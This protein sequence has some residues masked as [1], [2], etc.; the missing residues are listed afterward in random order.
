MH[1]ENNLKVSSA[2]SIAKTENDEP[3]ASASWLAEF[4]AAKG[5]NRE[6]V[7]TFS[8]GKATLRFN[9]N[10][11]T[12]HPCSGDRAWCADFVDADQSTIQLLLEQILKMRPF[13]S[14]AELADEKAEKKRVD[15]ALMGIANTVREGPDTGSGI[16]L[17]RFLWSLYNGHHLVNLWRMTCVLDATRSAWVSEVFVSAL[18]GTL[19][20]DD[21]KKT[22]V[23]AGEMERWDQVQPS[24]SHLDALREAERAIESVLRT[25]PP[26]H[27]HKELKHAQDA[28]CEA[29]AAIRRA[30][31]YP[32]SES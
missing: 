5:F 16:Q 18:V 28:L 4:L 11:L 19:K 23:A 20:E 26:C 17:R 27:S 30:K 6:S 8:N 25:L 32:E 3:L 12:A 13:L 1:T 15:A 9:G 31:E 22:L 24:A 2:D 14:D 7:E 10:K 29:E 21:I